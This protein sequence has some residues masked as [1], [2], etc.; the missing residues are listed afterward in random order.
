MNIPRALLSKIPII[1][2]IPYVDIGVQLGAWFQG[3]IEG[4][5]GGE[6]DKA[7]K[8]VV[9]KLCQEFNSK[10]ISLIKNTFVNLIILSV[11]ML[12]NYFLGSSRYPDLFISVAIIAVLLI[13]GYRSIINGALVLCNIV[14]YK[15]INPI[16][17]IQ[18]KILEEVMKEMDK[19]VDSWREWLLRIF[20][21]GDKKETARKIAEIDK[22]L[23]V[24]IVGRF[25]LMASIFIIYLLS[26]PSAL[27]FATGI[28][29]DHW[30]APVIWSV[31]NII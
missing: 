24:I 11:G 28:Y 21:P 4:V 7:K 25:A 1:K 20:G 31:K 8:E 14:E 30:Y 12:V 3:K 19:R 13:S 18:N 22:T 2:F 26:Y 23:M 29:F 17:I 6:I 5:I 27:H 10:I 9:K 15:S 16:K